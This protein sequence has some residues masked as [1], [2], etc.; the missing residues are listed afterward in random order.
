[1]LRSSNWPGLNPLLNMFCNV[2]L[3]GYCIVL[4]DPELTGLELAIFLIHPF[5]CW[6]YTCVTPHSASNLLSLTV[7]DTLCHLYWFL[8]LQVQNLEV[9]QEGCKFMY[10]ESQITTNDNDDVDDN[11]DNFQL[12]S[13]YYMPVTL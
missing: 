7:R 2:V 5:R 11:K 8:E 13:I 9:L 1:M 10:M 6:G 3:I 4:A 12:G